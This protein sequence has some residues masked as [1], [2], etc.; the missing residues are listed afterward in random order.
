MAD[1]F[2]PP[3]LAARRGRVF[4]AE[5]DRSLVRRA[6]EQGR[7]SEAQLTEA[8]E[9]RE[10]T[11][12]PLSEI[13]AGRGW[14]PPSDIAALVESMNRE[15]YATS[16]RAGGAPV[17]PDVV[18]HLEDSAR[19]LGGFVLVERLGRGGGGE[20]WKAWDLG[21]GRWCALKIPLA[22]PQEAAALERFAREAV[23]AARLS[24]PNIVS[25]HGIAEENG[26]PYIVMQY[27]EGKTIR[28]ERPPLHPP[29]Q[30]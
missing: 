12:R 3:G 29:A 27:V 17:P 25:I 28:Q 18:I 22:L 15:D 1:S 24:H 10:R 14:L 26:R 11:S 30:A 21:L 7:L 5:Q 23:V 13:L 16:R 6:V 9:E 4:G 19:R 2:V 8:W 20:V